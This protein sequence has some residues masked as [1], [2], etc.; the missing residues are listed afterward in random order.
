V[1]RLPTGARN[2]ADA[3]PRKAGRHPHYT[4]VYRL[5]LEGTFFYDSTVYEKAKG[6]QL[7]ME[8]CVSKIP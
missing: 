7:I 3:E 8:T 5:L 2:Q 4:R 1:L 6:L